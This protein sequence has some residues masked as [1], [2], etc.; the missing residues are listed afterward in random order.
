MGKTTID[1]FR[2]GNKAG[3]RMDHVRPG[4]DVISYTH[5]NA[6]YVVGRSGRN[7]VHNT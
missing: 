4:V 7:Y 5:N 1:L 2:A 6:D 3:P